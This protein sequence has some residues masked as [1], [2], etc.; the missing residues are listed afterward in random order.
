MRS[1]LRGCRQSILSL[2]LFLCAI[3]VLCTLPVLAPSPALAGPTERAGTVLTVGVPTDRCPMFYEDA[4]TG[5]VTGIGAD[6]MRAAAEETGYAVSFMPVEEETLKDALDN[7]AYDVVMPFGS[8]ITSASGKP[9]IVSDNLIQTPFTLVT[10]NGRKLPTISEITVGMLRSLG[11]AAETV[12][13]LYPGIKIE[14]FDTMAQSVDA[15]R[16]GSVDALLHNSYVWSY[17][18]QK[19]SYSDLRV[20]PSAM[21]SMDFRA[22]ALD[23]PQ[24]RQIISRLN[25]GIAKLGD[26][27]RQAIILDHTSRMLY[28]YDLSDYIYQYWPFVL[29]GVLLF[30]ALI[31]VTVLRRRTYLLE[32]EKKMQRLI[33][34][35]QLT[36]AL[37]LEG[38]KNRVQE[39][40]RAN[41]DVPYLL[42]Y[43]NIKGFKFANER[44]GRKAG[45]EL[46]RFWVTKTQETLSDVEAMGRI[47]GDHFAVLRRSGGEEQIKRDDAEVID[48]VRQY[49]I[50][51]NAEY[52]LHVCGGI[53]V[54]TAEDYRQV[55]V[56]RM[57]DYARQAEKNV[58]RSRDDGY[59]FYNPD[60][61][62][63]DR[64][65]ADVVRH[66]RVAIQTGEL[67]VWYQPQVDHATGRIIGAEA[68]CRW[69]HAKLGWL[70]PAEFIP[71][72]EEHGLIQKLDLFVWKRACEDLQRWNEQGLHRSVSINL[73]RSDLK[74]G[75]DIP[76]LFLDM[77]AEHGLTPDQL[78]IEITETAFVEDSDLL[79]DTT[80]RL[81][82]LGFQVE[83]DDFGSGYSSLNMLKEVPVDRIKLDLRF[84]SGAGDPE[85]GRIIVSHIIRMVG[86]LGMRLIAEGVENAE[87]ASFLQAS[88]CNEMQGFYFYKPM[89]VEDFESMLGQ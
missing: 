60:Q 84:L 30:V 64:R 78:R 12:G 71:V 18:L 19:P 88:G 32:Q 6:L 36:G 55:N 59:E 79:I 38:F 81:R 17:V 37:S 3:V 52:P 62:I 23:T 65:A 39:L 72:L 48:A 80:V 5:E 26:I 13:E 53:Y 49:F 47:E 46:L 45:D 22:G 44:L 20:Q 41:P 40:L 31:A 4:Q 1:A 21:F 77:V 9:S 86:A 50:D 74:G 87:Q 43:T 63:R 28:R 66:L 76:K 56:D 70:R 34:Y 58:R 69:E 85:R 68:L 67:Q 2:A 51:R 29:P 89:S 24:G 82:E 10:T 42:S 33:D 54:L 61:W 11:G 57:L 7:D 14:F 83:M 16:A 35:D 15:L 25:A 75:V 73:S 8:A 27:K